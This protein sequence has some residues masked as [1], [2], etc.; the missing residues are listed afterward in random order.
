MEQLNQAAQNTGNKVRI[1]IKFD[2]GMGRLGF[3]FEDAPEIAK[4]LLHLKWMFRKHYH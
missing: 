1:H 3:N 2:T 4:T